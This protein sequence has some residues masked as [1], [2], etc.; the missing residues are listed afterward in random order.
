MLTPLDETL[1]HQA[2]TTFDHA[3]TSDQRF[4][5]R[6]AAGVQH[7]A[8]LG[9]LRDRQLQEHRHVRWLLLRSPRWAAVQPAVVTSTAPRLRHD[10]RPAPDRG[11]RAAGCTPPDRRAVCAVPTA[12]RSHLAADVCGSR[13]VPPLPPAGRPG[14]AGLLPGSTSWGWGRDGLGS[15]SSGS[16]WADWF[17]WRDHLWGVRPGIGG[18]DPTTASADRCGTAPLDGIAL[19]LDRVPGGSRRRAVPDPDRRGRPE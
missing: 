17:A 2:P 18:K 12:L 11:D 19:H 5:D 15:A 8:L 4:F 1:M 9:D 3:V 16:T 13:G 6:W 7:P 10:A 14:G